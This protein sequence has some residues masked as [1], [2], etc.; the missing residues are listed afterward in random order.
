MAQPSKVEA[1]EQVRQIVR[2]LGKLLSWIIPIAIL[3]WLV[4]SFEGTKSLKKTDKPEEFVANYAT[5]TSVFASS[6]DRVPSPIEYRSWLGF[7]DRES[8]EFFEANASRIA[9][10]FNPEG[11]AAMA[12]RSV[13]EVR[14]E[15]MRLALRTAPLSGRFAVARSVT[16]D[17]GL[18]TLTLA[19]GRREFEVKIRR[20]GERWEFL[21]LMGQREALAGRSGEVQ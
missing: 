9:A 10:R 7:F 19:A 6:P 11:Q 4:T 2:G 5:F 21:D 14:L 20:D 13:E 17:D 12:G 3:V 18:H 1:A 16:G 15:A 8:R